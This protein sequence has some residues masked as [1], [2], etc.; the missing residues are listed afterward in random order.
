MFLRYKSWHLDLL[1][2]CH[3]CN[4]ALNYYIKKCNI[5]L[6]FIFKK[7]KIC[8]EKKRENILKTWNSSSQSAYNFFFKNTFNKKYIYFRISTKMSVIYLTT[9]INSPRDP[10]PEVRTGRSLG[11]MSSS[12]RLRTSKHRLFWQTRVRMEGGISANMASR[13]FLVCWVFVRLCGTFRN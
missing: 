1:P 10:T 6:Y 5:K 12:K 2:H 4:A 9:D 11:Q 3:S 13:A 7:I 8:T